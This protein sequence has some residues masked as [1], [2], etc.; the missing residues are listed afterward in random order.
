VTGLAAHH[1]R[2]RA[3]APGRLRAL[4]AV[5]AAV[6]AGIAVASGWG[7]VPLPVVLLLLALVA[8]AEL[9]VLPVRLGPARWATS[10]TEGAVGACLLVGDGAWSVVAVVGGVAVAQTVRRCPRRKR[11]LDLAVR[12]LGTAVAQAVCGLVG[13]G[14]AGAVAGLAVFWPL[15]CLLLATAVSAVSSRPLPSMLLWVTRQSALHTAVSAATGLLAAW[16]ALGAPAGLP[17]LVLGAVVARSAY[18][19]AAWRR[20]ESRLFAHLAEL[21]GRTHDAAAQLLVT[22]AARLL[23][24]ADV[25]LVVLHDRL[26]LRYT[27]DE[28]GRPDASSDVVA[29]DEPWVLAALAGPAVRR[30]REDGRPTLSAV[31]QRPDRPCAVLRARRPAGASAFDA[32]DLRAVDVLMARAD[33]WLR[34]PPDGTQDAEPRD[35]A[36][37]VRVR[38]SVERL[39]GL[40]GRG[41]RGAQVAAELQELERA[42]AALLGSAALPAAAVP[43]QR[44]GP[45]I[46]WTTTGVLR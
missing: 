37:V 28:R 16:L 2:R 46:E 1:P 4:A 8:A 39:D 33:A 27:G 13:G 34:T 6:G 21:P 23:H 38:A 3:A 40:A 22:A 9:V 18:A 14:L 36:A 25:E 19:H 31:L 20:A 5:C 15:S 32:T 7:G 35:E 45:A 43:A 30:G 17:G 12:L 41:A 29:L 44:S 42:V 24:G 11:E 26:A 10:L